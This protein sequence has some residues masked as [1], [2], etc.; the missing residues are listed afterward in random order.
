MNP[1]LSLRFAQRSITPMIVAGLAA[2]ALDAGL[3]AG[4][5]PRVGMTGA[6]IAN[7]S[8][9]ILY[10][11]V[12]LATY[13]TDPGWRPVMVAHL[14]RTGVPLA[15]ATLLSTPLLL[16]SARGGLVV[17]IP[18]ALVVSAALLRLPGVR[19]SDDGRSAL[20]DALP[21]RLRSPIS[22]GLRY[23]AGESRSLHVTD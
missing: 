5:V 8:S 4:L 23:L 22:K 2:A 17:G 3:A 6:V 11:L 9:G 10:L 14:R 15:A 7:A 1:V 13:M 19:I 21:R 12:G 18:L 20:L 16:L